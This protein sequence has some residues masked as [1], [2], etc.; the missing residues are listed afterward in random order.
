MTE[1][2]KKQKEYFDELSVVVKMINRISDRKENVKVTKMPS[3]YEERLE[4]L[5]N[6]IIKQQ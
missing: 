1:E 6:L 5:T 4:Q 3:G 2:L